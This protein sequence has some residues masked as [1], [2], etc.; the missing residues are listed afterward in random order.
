[1]GY[2]FHRLVRALA[3]VIPF[4]PFAVSLHKVV[5][6]GKLA[7]ADVVVIRE[8]LRSFLSQWLGERDLNIVLRNLGTVFSNIAAACDPG[9]NAW[10]DGGPDRNPWPAAAESAHWP[11]REV[12]D[13]VGAETGGPFDLVSR[14]RLGGRRTMTIVEEADDT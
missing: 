11:E 10:R 9:R 8:S 7:L 13:Q 12:P 3:S 6:G 1:V 4:V 5:T 14:F 2:K